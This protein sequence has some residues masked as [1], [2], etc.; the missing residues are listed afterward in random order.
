MTLPK[1]DLPIYNL[2]LKTSDK[3]IKFRPFVVKEERILMMALESNDFE[4]I[5]QAI[6]QV[7]NNCV[8]DEIE[9]DDLPLFELEHLFLNIRARSVGE[10]VDLSYICQN[11]IEE[12][13]RCNNEM[14][15]SV[16]LLKVDLETPKVET[17]LK[18]TDNIGIKLKY[19]TISVSKAIMEGGNDIDVVVKIIENCTEFL[20]DTEQAYKV[21]DMQ[22][23]E[24]NEFIEN[25]TREQFESLKSFFDNLPSI[26]YDT[27]VVCGK[28]GKEHKIH[29]EGLL[30]FFE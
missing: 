4:T 25:L 30:D 20:F 17:V 23:G 8:L 1:I 9:I 11:Q 6:K 16:D 26:K 21:E 24:F 13:V 3:N 7:I 27:Q 14:I 29:L 28:C 15:V 18:V 2:Q 22:P 19:P 12:N 5:M 10:N